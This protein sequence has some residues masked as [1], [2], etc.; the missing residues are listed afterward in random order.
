[1]DVRWSWEVGLVG[2]AENGD[3]ERNDPLR[4][5]VELVSGGAEGVRAVSAVVNLLSSSQAA[6]TN[7]APT[8]R[9]VSGQALGN[10]AGLEGDTGGFTTRE[11]PQSPKAY[12]LGFEGEKHP[13]TM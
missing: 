2:L 10:Q 3:Q 13:P 5:Y 12:E 9:P 1:M 8:G 4:V 11:N 6:S 7:S